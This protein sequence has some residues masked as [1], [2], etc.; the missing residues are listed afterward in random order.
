MLSW[1]GGGGKFNTFMGGLAKDRGAVF[2]E[3]AETHS[4]QGREDVIGTTSQRRIDRRRG[5][6]EKALFK[7]GRLFGRKHLLKR[8]GRVWQ[9]VAIQ[10]APPGTKGRRKTTE[11]GRGALEGEKDRR[12]RPKRPAGNGGEKKASDCRVSLGEAKGRSQQKSAK[13]RINIKAKL[14]GLG[15]K[16][17]RY[18]SSL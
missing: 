3:R 12:K 13:A 11:K 16:R 5:W 15:K 2:G 14:K 18:R 9:C 6:R 7:D 10:K 1:G 17:K 4:N 8:K